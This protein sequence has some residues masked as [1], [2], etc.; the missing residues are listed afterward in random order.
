MFASTTP[1]AFWR[2][3]EVPSEAL[4]HG[5]AR[6]PEADFVFLCSRRLFRFAGEDHRRP[7]Q[8]HGFLLRCPSAKFFIQISA[9]SVRRPSQA[10]PGSGE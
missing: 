3:P 2:S 7:H 9:Q 10:R 5:R 4:S 6:A 1:D 8:S